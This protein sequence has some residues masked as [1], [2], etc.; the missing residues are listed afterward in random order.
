VLKLSEESL[1]VGREVTWRQQSRID[2][3]RLA[4]VVDILF[5]HFIISLT[6][7]VGTSA[8]LILVLLVIGLLSICLCVILELF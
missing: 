6:I 1:K 3:L 8:V 2:E 5:V 7:P 4:L